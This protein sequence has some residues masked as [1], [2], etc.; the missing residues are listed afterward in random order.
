MMLLMLIVR[1]GP[2]F[3]VTERLQIATIVVAGAAGLVSG[4]DG[5]LGVIY[6]TLILPNICVLGFI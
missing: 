1:L 3:P 4:T 6:V 2:A 5:K